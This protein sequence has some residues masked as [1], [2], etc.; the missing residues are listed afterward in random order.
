MVRF[1][2]EFDGDY[3]RLID[4]VSPRQEEPQE[5]YVVPASLRISENR[6]AMLEFEQDDL[7]GELNGLAKDLDKLEIRLQ[8]ARR[9]IE[10]KNNRRSQVEAQI[11]EERKHLRKEMKR[12]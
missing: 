8:Y 11:R 5:E 10:N 12:L 4:I 2:D 6:L 9:D 1:D 7:T 3:V